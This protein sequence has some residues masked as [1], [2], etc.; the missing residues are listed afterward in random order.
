MGCDEP[1]TIG[2]GEFFSLS[3]FWTLVEGGAGLEEEEGG[4]WVV[5]RKRGFANETA[6]TE[7]VPKG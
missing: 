2:S 4:I 7:Q 6:G 5:R 3:Y 1:G